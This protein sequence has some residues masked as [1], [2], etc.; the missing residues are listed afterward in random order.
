MSAFQALFV[1]QKSSGA[2]QPRQRMYLPFGHNC[3]TVR[4]GNQAISRLK[5][6]HSVA[7]RAALEGEEAQKKRSVQR[8]SSHNSRTRIEMEWNPISKYLSIM[9]LSRSV[10]IELETS[11]FSSHWERMGFL[12]SFR[13]FRKRSGSL[14][15]AGT[16]TQSAEWGGGISAPKTPGQT[17]SAA[18]PH[19]ATRYH[20]KLPV[21]NIR[22]S[23]E[24]RSGSLSELSERTEESHSFPV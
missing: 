16:T 19:Q 17:Q 14:L 3:T 4:I 22:A 9:I 5:I 1:S 7:Q 6:L 10:S 11:F 15:T 12:S 8:N 18:P 13:Q 21:C 24:Q 23:G 20:A 2:Y